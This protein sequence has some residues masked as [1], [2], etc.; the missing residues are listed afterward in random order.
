VILFCWSEYLKYWL[1]FYFDDCQAQQKLYKT[2]KYEY[3]T[4][5]SGQQHHDGGVSDLYQQNINQLDT[6]LSDLEREQDSSIDRSEYMAYLFFVLY[7]SL[8]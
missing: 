4:T 2:T 8:S 6:L 7:K 1:V 3:K 5:K